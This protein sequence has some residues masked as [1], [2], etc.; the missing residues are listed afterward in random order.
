MS[1]DSI[2]EDRLARLVSAF[3]ARARA[4]ALL[5]PVFEDAVKDWPGHLKLLADFWSSVMLTTGSYKG[6][7]VAAHQRHADWITPEH[8]ARWLTL[9]AE[10]T[11]RELPSDAAAAMRDKAE[12]IAR[13]LQLA[14]FFKLPK[15]PVAA[16]QPE[17]VRP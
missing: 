14:L 4:D 15:P 16:A 7:P 12:R 10:V 2:T 17:G 6:N 1:Y 11:A 9:W 8:F 5:G 3:Y 13:S